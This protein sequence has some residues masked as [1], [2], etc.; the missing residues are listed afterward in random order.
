[1]YFNTFYFQVKLENPN[2][3]IGKLA[4]LIVGQN[5]HTEMTMK[6]V[7][8][9]TNSAT[10]INVKVTYSFTYSFH[11]FESHNSHYKECT[12]DMTY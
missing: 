8:M 6:M 3:N 9:V 5:L 2:K 11:T 10:E 12:K 7:P 4:F 1:M